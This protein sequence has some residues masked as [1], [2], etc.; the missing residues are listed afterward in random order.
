MKR[1]F[2]LLMM[3]VLLGCVSCK[4]KPGETDLL[5]DDQDILEKFSD[6]AEAETE[7]V[8][9]TEVA[10]DLDYD[11][12][13]VEEYPYFAN[14][15]DAVYFLIDQIIYRGDKES[16]SYKP[17]CSKE[18]CSHNSDQCNAYAEAWT[19]I[20]FYDEKIVWSAYE[21][22]SVQVKALNLSDETTENFMSISLAESIS[23]DSDETINW[24]E[25][26]LHRNYCFYATDIQ[27]EYTGGPDEDQS[28]TEAEKER[29]RSA[30][31]SRYEHRVLVNAKMINSGGGADSE[32][33]LLN[34]EYHDFSGCSVVFLP[35][36][37][38]IYFLV[39]PFI[40]GSF[41]WESDSGLSGTRIMHFQKCELYCWDFEKKTTECLYQG[42]MPCDDT[43]SFYADTNGVYIIGL[44]DAETRMEQVFKNYQLFTFDI[45]TKQ[46]SEG[47]SLF[48]EGEYAG[49]PAFGDGFIM[50]NSY[51]SPDPVSG[52]VQETSV[53]EIPTTIHLFS[54]NGARFD[55]FE[56]DEPIPLSKNKPQQYYLMFQPTGSDKD[57]IYAE[58][59]DWSTYNSGTYRYRISV[60]NHEVTMFARSQE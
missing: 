20:R 27:G 47:I 50:G 23:A 18:G 1:F 2:G 13:V 30:W 53:S 40:Y 32:F 5:I 12:S 21:A 51:P 45:T 52:G 16:A 38:G 3:V 54:L 24:A 46:F 60:D 14:S 9:E 15:N 31:E 28:E 10:K 35:V 22:D 48:R 41:F 4:S 33:S 42:S 11:L 56:F 6:T 26:V 49:I 19:G 44:K 34:Q 8:I 57:Y 7:E 25:P 55:S 29:L 58:Y 59:S 39:M 17:V 37:D 43:F 36:K